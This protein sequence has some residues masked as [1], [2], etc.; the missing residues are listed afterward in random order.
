MNIREFVKNMEDGS[1]MVQFDPNGN[2][3]FTRVELSEG[4]MVSVPGGIE[5]E[6]GVKESAIGVLWDWIENNKRMWYEPAQYLGVWTDL[7][8]TYIDRS[9]QIEEQGVAEFFGG[10]WDQ[11][12]IWDNAAKAEIKMGVSA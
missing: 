12:A 5:V 9:A 2:P 11:I 7:G 4:Y 6:L 8:V 10:L 1:Y 3:R